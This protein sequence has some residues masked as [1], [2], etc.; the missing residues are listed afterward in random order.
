MDKTVSGIDDPVSIRTQFAVY[1]IGT[2]N[3]SVFQ[4]GAVIIPLHAYT[5]NPSPFMFGLVFA[6]ALL[7]T[8]T[9]GATA[10][11]WLCGFWK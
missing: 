6:A 3:T 4:I 10:T 2:F 9:L 8:V 1:G 7:G 5:M 11:L